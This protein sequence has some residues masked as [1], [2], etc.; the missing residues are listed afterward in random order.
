MQVCCVLL[1]FSRFSSLLLSPLL[2]FSSLLLMNCSH[3]GVDGWV[4][5]D[6]KFL[7]TNGPIVMPAE[8]FHVPFSGIP[9]FQRLLRLVQQFQSPLYYGHYSCGKSSAL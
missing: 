6:G 3:E 8:Q 4:G 9:S 5:V 1:L 2:L 7:V